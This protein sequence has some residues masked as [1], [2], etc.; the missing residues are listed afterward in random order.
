M[1]DQNSLVI[2]DYLSIRRGPS[3]PSIADS[4]FLVLLTFLVAL[5]K[6]VLKAADQRE[7]T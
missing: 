3:H 4:F 2:V 5:L 1:L 7:L 6:L